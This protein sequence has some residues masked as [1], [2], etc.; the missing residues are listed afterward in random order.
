GPAPTPLAKVADTPSA[1]AKPTAAAAAGAAPTTA[2]AAAAPTTAAAAAAAPT[3]APA[4]AGPGVAE[5]VFT[6]YSTGSDRAIWEKTAADFTAKNP[7]YA[8]KYT[9]VGADSWGE[10]FDKL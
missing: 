1:A 8:I 9:P 7:K 5:I 2:V 3:T 6:N 4:A 10:Y